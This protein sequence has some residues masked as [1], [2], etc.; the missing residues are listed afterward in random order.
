MNHIRSTKRNLQTKLAAASMAALAALQALA[1]QAPDTAA[2][3]A[4]ETQDSTDEQVG[5]SEEPLTVFPATLPFYVPPHVGGGDRD[6]FSHGPN[7]T[8]VVDLVVLYDKQVWAS[9]TIDAMETQSNYTHAGGTQWFFLYSAAKTITSLGASTHFDYIYLD[10]NHS[11]DVF[12]FPPGSV[13]K[14]LSCVGD[15]KGKESGTA[16]GCSVQLHPINMT[17]AK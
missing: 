7:M 12:S 17:L 4:N 3:D 14:S 11:L 13:V 8:V 1:C 10:S 15:T 5:V 6:F 16:T 9:V 2:E